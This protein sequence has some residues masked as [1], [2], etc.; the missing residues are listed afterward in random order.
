MSL[1]SWNNR[2]LSHT[3]YMHVLL[4]CEFLHVLS[5]NWMN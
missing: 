5:G 2:R 3:V 4:Q 1:V